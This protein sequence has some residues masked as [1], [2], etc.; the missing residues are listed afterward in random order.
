MLVIG[1]QFMST[2]IDWSLCPLVESVPGRVGG[3]PVLLGTRMPVDDIL[4]N[5]DY[6]VSI[7]EIAEQFELDESVVREVVSYAESVR[8]SAHIA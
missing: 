8:P 5:F 7:E 2:E 3:R 6:G 4:A 1:G